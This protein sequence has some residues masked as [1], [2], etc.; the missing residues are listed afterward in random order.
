MS[1]Y[2]QLTFA[3]AGDV[4]ELLIAELAEIGFEG[5]EQ[6]ENLMIAWVPTTLFGTSERGLISAW[7]AGRGV[8]DAIVNEK[9]IKPRNWNQE[10]EQNIEP[11]TIGRF[12]VR[13]T[14]RTEPLP[15]GKILL[16]IDPKMAFGTGY[17]ETTRLML[18]AL[19]DVVDSGADILD[20]G[21]GTGIL[22]IASL[23]LGAASAFGFDIDEWSE[24]NA[25]ENA[26]KNDSTTN[27]EVKQGSFDTVVEEAEFDLVLANVN[28][29]AILEMKNELVA[30]VKPGGTLLLSG[31]L[32][33]EKDLI[34]E[35][36]TFK[37]LKLE[38]VSAENEWV[39]IRYTK[40]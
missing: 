7:F 13:P 25:R 21:T 24:D 14:W 3:V 1:D 40:V 35:E 29:N 32:G 22:A 11:I 38:D 36:P 18:R 30:H 15:D 16:N 6:H 26:E 9:L 20:V 28:R 5:F 31:V 10:W 33:V 8:S 12:F 39:S 34:L 2:Q 19:P 27:F 23:K 4:Q 17:H 37:A